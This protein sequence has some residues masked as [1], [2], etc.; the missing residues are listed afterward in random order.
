MGCRRPATWAIRWNNPKIH[1]AERRKTWHACDEHRGELMDFLN[2]RSFVREV[3]A[4][5]ADGSVQPPPEAS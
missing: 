1:T 4:L 3:D 2:R 5:A